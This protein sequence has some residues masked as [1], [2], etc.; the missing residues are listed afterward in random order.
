MLCF[1]QSLEQQAG[2]SDDFQ[3]IGN[4]VIKRKCSMD[5]VLED[6]ICGLYDLYV[7]VLTC[8]LLYPFYAIFYVRESSLVLNILTVYSLVPGA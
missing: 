4:E 8:L 5:D 7:E 6:R 2:A 3:E 1:F